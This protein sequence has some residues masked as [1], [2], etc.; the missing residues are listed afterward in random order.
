MLRRPARPCP[1]HRWRRSYKVQLSQSRLHGC[2][3][4]SGCWQ[5]PAS[6][7]GP[8]AR[9]RSRC[10]ATVLSAAPRL[11]WPAPGPQLQNLSLRRGAAARRAAPPP[12]GAAQ[13]RAQQQH[14]APRRLAAWASGAALPC[15]CRQCSPQSPTQKLLRLAR[16]SCAAGRHSAAASLA[17]VVAAAAPAA[18][19][20]FPGPLWSL[21]ASCCLA[22]AD[23]ADEAGG[24]LGRR[25]PC[26]P[27]PAS[28]QAAQLAAP[29]WRC[30]RAGRRRCLSQL[31]CCQSPGQAAEALP[32]AAQLWRSFPAGPSG[33]A[34][35]HR[36]RCHC[37]TA[38]PP[39][40]A[41]APQP[42]CR[43]PLVLAPAPQLRRR[44]PRAGR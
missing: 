25:G 18:C 17:L 8:T 21:Q 44:L 35:H 30:R 11:T 33:T 34:R 19:C 29:F 43:C 27:P 7:A 37:S 40:P 31:R 36:Q 3:T 16:A 28:P 38:C 26:P 41:R 23:E 15:R 9:P 6:A 10:R 2:A 1:P 12:A 5:R 22:A 20:L 42:Q 13:R 24:G 4:A 32:V 39:A 14:A